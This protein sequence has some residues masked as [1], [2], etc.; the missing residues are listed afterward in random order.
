MIGPDEAEQS[1]EGFQERAVARIYREYEKVLA[2]QNALDFDDLLLRVALLLRDDA[3]LRERLEDRYRYV[4]IDEYQDTNH[5]QYVIARGLALRRHNL[6]ATG[7]PDQSIYGW[8]GAN[9]GN[10]LEF[11]EDFPETKVVRLEQNYR[12]TGHILAAAD[13]VIRCN[14]D[15]RRKGLWTEKGEGE[16]V[17]IVECDSGAEEAEFIARRIGELADDGCGYGRIAVFY[18]INALTRLLEDAL[19]RASIP[20]RI[21]RGVEFYNRKEIKDVLAYLRVLVNPQDEVALVRILNTPAR[22]IGDAT[23]E[24]LREHARATGRPMIHGVHRP[25]EVPGL[26][27]AAAR[28]VR[29]FAH[30]LDRLSPLVNASAQEAIEQVMLQSGLTAA[31]RELARTDPGPLENVNELIS[32]AAEY[33]RGRPDGSLVEWL[34]QVSLVSDQDAYD[35]EAGTVTLMTLHAAKG[36]EFPVVFIAGCE[37]GLLPHHQ[38]RDTRSELEEERRLFFVG[39][40]RA[41][42]RLIL[43]HAR[44][45]DFRGMT[46]R[47]DVSR[48]LGEI[49]ADH[50]RT[51]RLRDPADEHRAPPDST[52]EGV[53]ADWKRGQLVLH[54]SYGVGRLMWI[55]RNPGR[56]RAAVRFAAYGE[57][58]FVLEYCKLEPIDTEDCHS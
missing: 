39:M 36:L 15:R 53:S 47:N 50:A 18:R 55:Q 2:E 31:L 56:T 37:E 27:R 10:I 8:R 5:A 58:V 25:D 33:D 35:A 23:V 16:P 12:S 19:R 13:R 34:H 49:P 57:K 38:H 24:R 43:T 41:Q 52:G 48:F 1:A 17:S 11:E 6:C 9:L 44:F 51:V 28:K 20:Y 46:Q 30:L 45:R 26:A 7:D 3:E 4:L 29:E 14:R 54:P 40:T 32:A 42:E 21:V 22:G